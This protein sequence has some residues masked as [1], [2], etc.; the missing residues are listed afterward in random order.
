MRLVRAFIRYD[1]TYQI[2]KEAQT[3]DTLKSKHAYCN[4]ILQLTAS[5]R[6]GLQSK[7]KQ[8]TIKWVVIQTIELRDVRQKKI[9]RLS[10]GGRIGNN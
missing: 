6:T 3:L 2:A 5:Q 10:E 4:W 9:K 7:G 8:H 1:N